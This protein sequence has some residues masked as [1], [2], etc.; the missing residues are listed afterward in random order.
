MRSVISLDDLR[1]ADVDALTGRAV[2]FGAGER[3]SALAGRAVG[4]YFQKSSTRTRTSF[5]RAAT[6]LGAQV[7]TYGPDD[8]QLTT[9]ESL[10]DTARV[11]SSY[12]D[13]LVVRTNGDIAELRE[14]AKV[15]DIAVV[16]ALTQYEHPTQALADIAT[17]REEFGDLSGRHLL[18]VGEGNSTAAALVRAVE[19]TP[20]LALTVVTPPGYGVPADVL[21][22]KPERITQHHDLDALPDT[23]D[24]VYTSRWQTMGVSKADPDW[25]R[26][27]EPYQVDEFLLERVSHEGT[28]FLHDLPAVRGQEVTDKVLDGPRSRA[29]RQAHHKMTIAMAV[30]E[31]CVVGNGTD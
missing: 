20:G 9:G 11:L 12:L 8:L 21:V 14:L 1:A 29:W 25:L 24:V 3:S 28:I 2:E 10:E 30:L 26:A 4:V 6:R 7:I 15:G 5:W 16:N 31:W 13:A 22:G 27:F 23:V 19:L 17:L 18:Y